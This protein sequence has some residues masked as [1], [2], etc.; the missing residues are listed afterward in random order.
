MTGYTQ[1]IAEETIA[2]DRGEAEVEA[3]YEAALEKA[4]KARAGKAADAAERKG[5]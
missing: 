1:T 3:R 5:R 2:T 4:Q